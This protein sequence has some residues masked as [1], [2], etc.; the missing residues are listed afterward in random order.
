MEV[1]LLDQEIRTV[2]TPSEEF[3]L[4]FS[5]K[6]P[7][8]QKY[9]ELVR[10]SSSNFSRA[11]KEIKSIFIEGAALVAAGLLHTTSKDQSVVAQVKE[12]QASS[13]T[14]LQSP[15]KRTVTIRLLCG[16]ILYV[17]TLYCAPDNKGNPRD[18]TEAQTG[19]YPELAAYG[20]A[21]RSS[22]A[23]EE[24]V[25]RRVA[26]CPSFE[27]A[28]QELNR[29]GID[30]NV[31][32][33]RRIALQFGESILAMRLIMVQDF[34]AGTLETTNKLAGKRVVISTD[35]GRMKLRRNKAKQRKN[36]G[37][38]GKKKSNHPQYHTNWRE[39]KMF[40]V[41]TIDKHGKKEEESQVWL[42]GTFQGP[43]NLAELLAAKLYHLGISQAESVTFIADG[44]PWICDR[45][46]W[47]VEMLKLPKEKVQY[48]L[49]FYHAAHHISLA[50]VE[51][52]L[53]EDERKKVYKELRGE[54]K[55][56]RWQVV[57]DQLKKLGSAVPHS[58][59]LFEESSIFCRE[60]RF[61]VKHGVAY[62][63]NY[64]TYTRRGLPIGSG[65]VESAIR[66]VINLRL[67]GNGMFWSE[68]NAEKMLQVRCLIMSTEWD[69]V[70][71]E[72]YRH[73]LKTRRRKWQWQA[74]DHCRKAQDEA[75][76]TE[77]C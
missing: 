11:E 44:A 64:A 18:N 59:S 58:E 39:P 3:A 34:L 15:Q 43:D 16:L 69:V 10:E 66:R 20:F 7:V 23:L 49:D 47:L 38:Q 65:A 2:N 8:I 36:K 31:K 70:L 62:H 48:V 21:K 42:D 74:G 67:K 1:Q 51:L 73:R 71:D 26:Y 77:K 52:S 4:W 19:L 68:E 46:D 54:L 14:P 30:I 24:H 28:T 33:V 53:P 35:G 6:V 41:Y 56:S 45:F 55:N 25:A 57:I 9:E 17:T 5:K 37:K 50:L 22:A 76:P 72:L 29:E 40:I 60:L 61:F 63:L 27:I 12:I 75:K 13:N 32:E